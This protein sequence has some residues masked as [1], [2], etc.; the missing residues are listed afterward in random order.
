MNRFTLERGL[1][2]RCAGCGESAMGVLSAGGDT[3]RKRCTKCQRAVEIYLPDL[4]KKAVYLDQ[5]MFS[6]IYNVKNHGN[7]PLGHEAFAKEVYFLLRRC[8]LLQQ[9]FLPHSDIHQKETMAFHSSM[10][11]R[12]LYEFFGGDVRLSDQLNVVLSQEMAFAEAFFDG[13]EPVLSFD[14]DEVT[15]S[16]HNEWLQDMHIDVRMDIGQFAEDARRVRAES[17]LAM[18]G[19]SQVWVERK[20]KFK[21][22]LENE[23]ASIFLTKREEMYRWARDALSPN[24]NDPMAILEVSGR[25]IAREYRELFGM[26]EARGV[27]ESGRM[28]KI[29][30]F[31]SWQR[32]RE[33][34]YHRISA[35]FFAAV[36]RRVAMGDKKVIDRGLINDV[37]TISTYAP[38]VDALFVDKKC[39]A[40]LAEEPLASDLS[41]KAEIFS[42][43]DPEA[44]IEYLKELEAKTPDDVRE[45]AERIYQVT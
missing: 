25:K 33:V 23:F 35:Y 39:A 37:N 38:Y 24:L 11:L 4:D 19:L 6:L 27:E 5:F 2:E 22:L 29:M 14:L 42:L 12:G 18:Q 7:L 45:L 10:N 43:S 9:I 32:L 36:A 21:D 1:F 16:R 41:Y 28:Q 17:Y 26:L 44:F 34:P 8:V 20:I 31:W 30:D 15:D 13:K 40:I 3:L